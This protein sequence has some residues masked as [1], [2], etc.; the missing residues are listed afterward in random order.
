MDNNGR[1]EEPMEIAQAVAAMHRVSAVYHEPETT[2]ASAASADMDDAVMVLSQAIAGDELAEAA[3]DELVRHLNA[4][5][6][7]TWALARWHDVNTGPVTQNFSVLYTRR[8]LEVMNALR[9]A[10]E[11]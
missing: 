3:L 2:P 8:W 4:H 10:L 11:L 9:G 5:S 6:N 1:S 7:V